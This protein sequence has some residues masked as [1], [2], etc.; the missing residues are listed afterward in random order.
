MEAFRLHCFSATSTTSILTPL[1]FAQ[2]HTNNAST[3]TTP[4]LAVHCLLL[5]RLQLQDLFRTMSTQSELVFFC[6]SSVTNAVCT[7][8]LCCVVCAFALCSSHHAV[9][10]DPEWLHVDLLVLLAMEHV[11]MQQCRYV[12][13]S[14]FCEFLYCARSSYFVNC[15]ST[16][17]ECFALP[18]LCNFA[19][20]S[21]S[22]VESWP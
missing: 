8:L 5:L 19:A 12:C 13:E 22:G 2:H 10:D 6:R 4:H 14:V 21:W 18:M 15:H 9:V 17:H 1:Y 7:A 20:R 11:V 3:T 16:C